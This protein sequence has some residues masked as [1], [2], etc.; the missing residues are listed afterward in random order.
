MVE[1]T[2]P[3]GPLSGHLP[4]LELRPQTEG[5]EGVHEIGLGR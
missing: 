5:R 2:P 4:N 3:Q 1:T